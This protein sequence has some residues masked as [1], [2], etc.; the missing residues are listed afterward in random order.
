VGSA[1][2]RVAEF[3]HGDEAAVFD[4]DPAVLIPVGVLAGNR[5]AN[6]SPIGVSWRRLS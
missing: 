6:A 5:S 1:G 2:V 4:H 3:V